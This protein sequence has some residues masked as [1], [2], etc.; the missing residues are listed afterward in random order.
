LP[1]VQVLLADIGLRAGL[2]L[3]AQLCHGICYGSIME[4][5]AN[6]QFDFK[7][8]DRERGYAKKRGMKRNA[9]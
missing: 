5:S 8:P 3:A 1:E 2:L 4:D 9:K 7:L 6:D